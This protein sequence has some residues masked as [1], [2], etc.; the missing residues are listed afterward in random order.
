MSLLA[1]IDLSQIE[2][3]VT[4]LLVLSLLVV[5]HE[6][7]HFLLAR[8]N[9]V[10]VIEFAVGMGPKI[11]GV[12]SKRT[13]TLY[14]IRALPV[15]GYCQMQ[16]E[17]G[18]T[19]PAEQQREFQS[20]QTRDDD[21]FQ[22]QSPWR[23]LAIVLAGPIA[24]FILSLAILFAG[25][26]LFGVQSDNAQPL[27]GPV[28]NGMPAQRAGLEAGDRI[29]AINGQRIASGDQLV[30]LIHDSLGKALHVLYERN[31]VQGHVTVTPT[32]CPAPQSAL[33]CIGF[34]P[35]PEYQ[36]VGFVQA[37]HQ[38]LEQFAGIAEQTVGGLALLVRHPS[39]YAGG[40]S[41]PVGIGQAAVTIQDFGWGPY[42]R[43]AAIIS[44]AL[45]LFNLLPVPALDGG[46]AAFI[47]AELVR[48]KP[49]DPEKEAMVHIAG[50]AVLLALI[51]IVTFHDITRIVQGKGV[52]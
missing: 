30:G 21:N 15:G 52:F 18:K 37:A 27:V 35:V 48:R 41:G 44:F 9:G 29:L 25:A 39:Q 12:R 26:L 24:N 1:L 23:R 3:I 4:F 17:D 34:S 6:Y 22:A 47:I 11:V 2:K 42:L 32:H 14:S 45:G 40:V 50:F 43:F 51:L 10:R 38:S 31:G 36:R 46:R 8:L 49:V 19:S 7:G 33:G 20:A 16:G 28:V 5:L 13:G